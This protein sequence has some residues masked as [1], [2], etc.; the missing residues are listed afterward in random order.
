MRSIHLLQLT[1]PHLYADAAGESYGVNTATSL[2]RVL[3]EV[4]G[5]DQ[6]RPDAIV[7]T[8]DLSD[9]MSRA[10]YQNLRAA[11]AQFA[12]PV[13]CLPGNHD[14]PALMAELLDSDGVHYCGRAELADWGLVTVDTH[15]PG[16][17]GGRISPAGL[18]RLEDDLSAFRAR[19]VVVCMHHPPVP[20][21]SEW[22]DRSSLSNAPDFFRV[23]ERHPQVKSV[24]AGHV[25]QAFD[26]QRGSVR[27]LTTPSTCAQFM[28]RSARF[29]TDPRPPGYRWLTLNADG[30]FRTEAHWVAR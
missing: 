12:A 14:D 22:L 8:G 4:R 24:L 29:A 17:V 10:S 2:K 9:D 23:V 16:R 28:P 5:G 20:I 25:H 30:T 18:T 6:P 26:I 1:D 13:R 7:V 21:D 19:P 27:V 15:W 11:L 3:D